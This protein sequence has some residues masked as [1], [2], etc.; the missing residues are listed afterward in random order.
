MPD[1]ASEKEQG[2][3]YFKQK[4]FAQA[5]ECYSRSI[6]LID[7]NNPELRK[8]YS[9]IKALH[10]KEVANRS[11]PTK[12]T[13]FKFDKSGDKKDTSHAPSSSQKDSFM[14]VDPPSRVAVEIREK[15]DGTSKG[16]S[17]VIFKDSTIQN[18]G[19]S[20]IK[21][22]LL[23][24]HQQIRLKPSGNF[25]PNIFRKDCRIACSLQINDADAETAR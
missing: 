20:G 15:A 19:R 2:N 22:S 17:G 3:E 24:L 7:P 13:V 6:G 8:Q 5:I 16:G 25:E 21:Y 10:M 4:K 12:H 14:E 23:K 11:K 1:A 9:E 18:Y